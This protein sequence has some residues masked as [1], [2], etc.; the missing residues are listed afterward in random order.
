MN[1]SDLSATGFQTCTTLDG[2]LERVGVGRRNGHLTVLLS[3]D[4]ADGGPR[5]AQSRLWSDDPRYYVNL[6]GV[7]RR[8]W[9]RILSGASISAIAAEEGVSR[10]AIY[11]RIQGNSEGHGGMIAKNYW[12]LLWWRLRKSLLTPH[13]QDQ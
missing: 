5:R 12:C 8:T 11:A 2:R 4:W 13:R 6:N 9:R 7:E 1:H 10:A 3:P